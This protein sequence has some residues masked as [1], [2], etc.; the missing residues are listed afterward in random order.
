MDRD[1]EELA[2]RIVFLLNAYGASPEIDK[3]HIS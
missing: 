3:Y 2:E 1:S